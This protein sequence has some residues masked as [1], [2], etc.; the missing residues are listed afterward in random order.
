MKVTPRRRSARLGQ[1]LASPFNEIA[2]L[3]KIL[4][5]ECAAHNAT[6]LQLHEETNRRI[7]IEVALGKEH[8]KLAQYQNVNPDETIGGDGFSE[9]EVGMTYVGQ[10]KLVKAEAMHQRAVEEREKKLGEEHLDTLT[11][12][13]LYDKFEQVLNSKTIE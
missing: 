11:N 5:D 4:Q 8:D 2:N 10:G 3:G 13:V 6:R 12:K 7:V 1:I 9:K